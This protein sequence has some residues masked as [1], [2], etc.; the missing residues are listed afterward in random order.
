MAFKVEGDAM[1][2]VETVQSEHMHWKK[3]GRKQRSFEIG[4][5]RDFGLKYLA[6]YQTV[7]ENINCLKSIDQIDPRVETKP[8]G[9]G[10]EL[11]LTLTSLQA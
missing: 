9:E 8:L 7:A 2:V 5:L 10:W 3:T 4:F 1:S 6:S 11:S